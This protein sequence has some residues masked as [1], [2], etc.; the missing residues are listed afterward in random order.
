LLEGGYFDHERGFPAVAEVEVDANGFVVGPLVG[1]GL[2]HVGV[3]VHE[4]M[5]H[6]L[7]VGEE[8]GGDLRERERGGHDGAAGHD[9]VA[10]EVV[11]HEVRHVVLGCFI[12]EFRHIDALEHQCFFICRRVSCNK[13]GCSV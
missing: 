7:L 9:V 8:L 5:L 3:E 12:L 2:H 4:E 11:L 10:A 1:L 13:S 6:E